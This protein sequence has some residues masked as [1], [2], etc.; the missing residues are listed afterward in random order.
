MVNFNACFQDRGISW[1]TVCHLKWAFFLLHQAWFLAMPLCAM[2]LDMERG[3]KPPGSD[4]A[5]NVWG[6][7]KTQIDDQWKRIA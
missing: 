5:L 6:K 3:N 7:V 1:V 2:S 4:M